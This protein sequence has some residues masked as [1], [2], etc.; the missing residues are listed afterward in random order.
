LEDH[1]IQQRLCDKPPHH[2]LDKDARLAYS[3]SKNMFN[4]KTKHALVMI[5]GQ[6]K[7]K[8]HLSEAVDA[9]KNVAVRDVLENEHPPPAA[10]VYLDCLETNNDSSNQLFLRLWMAP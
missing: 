7:G 8:L 3:F 2:D 6:G 10:P 9:E 5:S 4:G 1:A